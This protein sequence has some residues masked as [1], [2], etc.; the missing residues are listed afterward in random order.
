MHPTRK[1]TTTKK[2]TWKNKER[3]AIQKLLL[4][5][6]NT[7]ASKLK[8]QKRKLLLSPPPSPSHLHV[9]NFNGYTIRIYKRANKYTHTFNCCSVYVL[10]SIFASISCIETIITNTF[11]WFNWAHRDLKIDSLTLLKLCFSEEFHIVFSWFKQNKCSFLSTCTRT[12][13]E[14]AMQIKTKQK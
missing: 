8:K 11:N 2:T 7:I 3:K 9:M 10:K 5:K 14:N 13:R 1:T 4:Q 12:H 6:K